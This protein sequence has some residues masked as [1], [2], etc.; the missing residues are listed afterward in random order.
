MFM[1]GIGALLTASW[2]GRMTWREY[3]AQ[4]PVTFTEK[5][6]FAALGGGI[7]C[8]VAISLGSFF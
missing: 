6:S 5:A 1:F 2:L 8:I 7:L 3:V 4:P